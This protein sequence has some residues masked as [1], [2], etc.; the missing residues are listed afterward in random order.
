MAFGSISLGRVERLDVVEVVARASRVVCEEEGYGR[1][2]ARVR[3]AMGRREVRCMVGGF[4]DSV[5]GVR[6]S[7][8]AG[9]FGWVV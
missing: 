3:M 6:V 9:D 7:Y 4:W 8:G 2:V 5:V 1:A